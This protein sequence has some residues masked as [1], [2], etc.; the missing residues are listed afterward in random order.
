MTSYPYHG[1]YP[2]LYAFHKPG[3]ALDHQAMRAQI[4]HCLA[5]GA[6][7]LMALGL[8]TEVGK[9][10][11]GERH[12][13]VGAVAEA[14]GR[15]RPFMVTVGE[16]AQH[17]QLA[18][19]REARRNGA[20]VIILQP[21]P[22]IADEA[23]LLRFFGATADAL[24]CPVAVQHNPFN[25]AVNLSLDGLV[26]LHR[27]HPNV[28]VLKGEG[29]AVETAELIERSGGRLANFSGHGGIELMTNLRAGVAGLIPA[30]D[31]LA[32][33]V[34]IYELFR[35][36]TSQDL[37]EAERLHAEVLPLIVF[38]IRSIGQALCYGKRFYARQI[39]VEIAHER[40]PSQAPTA[41]GLAE[42]ARLYERYVALARSLPAL[43]AP[44]SS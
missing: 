28:T 31:Q 21:P 37:A 14:L 41:F 17:E 4:E 16:P 6:H 2:V 19:A 42:M 1:I 26:S 24:D 11:T 30:P 34:R 3:G 38:M 9:H 32:V 20:D 15:R 23:A 10:T 36:S 27:N 25:L 44:R 33:Q 12:E 35:R 7:G 8:I 5:N 39:G 13:I 29:T 22:A 18:F 40:E 43:N